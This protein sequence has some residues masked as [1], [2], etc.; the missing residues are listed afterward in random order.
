MDGDA[1]DIY[2]WT[3]VENSDYLDHE[4]IPFLNSEERV[5]DLYE[6]AQTIPD[7]ILKK[8]IIDQL[9]G[10][11]KRIQRFMKVLSCNRAE[12]NRYVDFKNLL[13]RERVLEWMRSVGVE[14]R[15]S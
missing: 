10:G 11:R 3:V 14:V 12:L 4:Y 8:K 7:A 1:E 15:L 5:W 13:D 6:F 2:W 9:S